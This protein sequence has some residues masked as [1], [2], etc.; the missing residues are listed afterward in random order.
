MFITVGSRD[1]ELARAQSKQVVEQL[2][3]I[4]DVRAEMTTMSS[5]GDEKNDQAIPEIGETGVFTSRLDAAVAEDEVDVAVHS[6][7][8]RPTEP[9]TPVVVGAVPPRTTPMDALVGLGEPDLSKLPEDCVIGTSS[10]RRRANLLFLNDDLT[11]K[12]CRGNVPSRLEKLDDDETDYDG[13][14]LAMAGLERLE[15]SV[16]PLRMIRPD[17]ILPAPAQGAL[18]VV[19]HEK[20]EELAEVLE[21]I[22][23]DKSRI[24]CEAERAFLNEVEGGCQAPVGA[25][26]KL[27]GDEIVLQGSVTHPDGED[28]VGGELHGDSESPDDLGRE[29]ARVLL[30]NGAG[31]FIQS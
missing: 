23:H 30:N 7:K 12:P 3:E 25:L 18:A 9:D 17:E 5:L 15:S 6:F 10:V 26:G 11:V 22:N 8:D 4:D 24:L 31:E 16:K 21:T 27:S 13:L 2:N 14:V 29:L 19:H 28:Q 20:R 1:S